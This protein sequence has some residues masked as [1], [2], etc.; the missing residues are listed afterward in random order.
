[1]HKK[2]FFMFNEKNAYFPLLM[3][4]RVL[5]IPSNEGLSDG[6]SAQHCFIR[7][8]M[9]GFMPSDSCMGSGGL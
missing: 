3:D 2:Y 4:F 1:M 6:S 5:A 7:V 8:K 9:P